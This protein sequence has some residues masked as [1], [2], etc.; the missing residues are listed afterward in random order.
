MDLLKA[1]KICDHLITSHLKLAKAMREKV[2]DWSGYPK[3]LAIAI[4]ETSETVALSVSL[5]KE[6]I[7]TNCKH[8]KKMIDECDGQ[9]YCMKCNSNID[10]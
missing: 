4:A 3:D 2:K 9:K 6:N 7:Q 8:P 1:V 5:I 10:D